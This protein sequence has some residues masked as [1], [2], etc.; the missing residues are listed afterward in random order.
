PGTKLS[1]FPRAG[2]NWTV[3]APKGERAGD[4]AFV[5]AR[6]GQRIVRFA[7]LSVDSLSQLIGHGEIPNVLDWLAEKPQERSIERA[8]DTNETRPAYMLLYPTWMVQVESAFG[9]RLSTD[10]KGR[11]VLVQGG[12]SVSYEGWLALAAAFAARGLDE[13]DP[14]DATLARMVT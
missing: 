11:P 8:I 1:I 7:P 9:S 3:P 10:L 2:I 6:T 5:D 14:D 13:A 12:A 4:I